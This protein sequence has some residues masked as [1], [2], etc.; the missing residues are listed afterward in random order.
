MMQGK[1][2]EAGK[3][4]FLIIFRRNEIQRD[5]F[6][7]RHCLCLASPSC[8]GAILIGAEKRSAALYPLRLVVVGIVARIWPLRIARD[9]DAS[10]FQ[11]CVIILSVVITASLPDVACHVEQAVAIRRKLGDGGKTC[12]TIFSRILNRKL[13]L[14]TIRHPLAPRVSTRQKWLLPLRPPRVAKAHSA[15]VGNRLP[16]HF[17]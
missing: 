9:V 4:E 11:P 16:A 15:S 5:C 8:T 13:P 17:A 7:Y 10:K 1:H 14:I 3:L 6:Q 2:E 12:E